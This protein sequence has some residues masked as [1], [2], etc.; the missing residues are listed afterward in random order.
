MLATSLNRFSVD[1]STG[2]V[3]KDDAPCT[4]PKSLMGMVLRSVVVHTG[5]P[6]YGHYV[7]YVNKGGRWW[8]CDDAR[9]IEVG[10][11]EVRRV[12]KKGG[13]LMFWER[14]EEAREL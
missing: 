6:D 3:T 9:I 8:L 4:I 5:T 1:W 13:Y 2:R 7:A 14:D 12:G 10:W 11:G